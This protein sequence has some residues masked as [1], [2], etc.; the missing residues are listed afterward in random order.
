MLTN[1]MYFKWIKIII[2]VNAIDLNKT[3]DYMYYINHTNRTF[4]ARY[5]NLPLTLDWTCKN[6]L[7]NMKPTPVSCGHAYKTVIGF[8][9]D[10]VTLNQIR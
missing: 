5:R 2:Q 4:R 9:S 6:R 3:N 10:T 8:T 1:K 7:G